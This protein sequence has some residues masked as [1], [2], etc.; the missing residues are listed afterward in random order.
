MARRGAP[1]KTE[2]TPEAVVM[3]CPSCASELRLEAEWLEDQTDLLA[4]PPRQHLG[5]ER[6]NRLLQLVYPLSTSIIEQGGFP[7]QNPLGLSWS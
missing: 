7:Q 5:A 2:G 1:D 3:A 4:L 6:Y